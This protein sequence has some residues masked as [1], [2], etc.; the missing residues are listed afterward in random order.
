M[1]FLNNQESNRSF[2]L[3]EL[4]VVIAIVGLLSSIV[5]V[6]LQGAKDQADIAKAQHFS[7]QVR[8][9]LGISLIGEWRL[10]DE[11][12]PT[13]DSSGNGN[14]GD[15]IDF[16]GIPTSGW[17]DNGMFGKALVF[18]GIDDY[19][20]MPVSG[21]SDFLDFGTDGN[22]CFAG[23][24]KTAS[25]KFQ[26]WRYI[27]GLPGCNSGLLEW[28]DGRLVAELREADC[29]LHIYTVLSS[30]DYKED[31]WYFAVWQWSNGDLE[32]WING[33]K[34]VNES[35]ASHNNW[36]NRFFLS[37]MPHT[38][39]GGG[40]EGIIDNVQIYNDVLTITEIQ[41]LYVQGA[42]KYGIVLK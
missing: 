9:N 29:A 31:K 4:L 16:N 23:W 32:V 40:F 2:T 38:E 37:A 33:E 42:A 24:F 35:V 17:T 15:L 22:I 18:D 5:L 41:Q 20:R 10:D 7:Q 26:D 28:G 14:H 21:S 11:V 39:T 27:F 19:V 12:D 6:S 1:I 8:S 34:K 13:R 25:K 3:I 36:G 30:S